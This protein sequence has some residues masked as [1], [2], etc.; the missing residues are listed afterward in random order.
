MQFIA[1][2]LLYSTL[3]IFAF[4]V[5]CL[6][7]FRKTWLL[8][9]LRANVGMLLLFAG[10]GG[11]IGLVLLADME[12]M[13]GEIQYGQ[14][15]VRPFGGGFKL[16]RLN[17]ERIGERDVELTSKDWRL[18]AISIQWTGFLPTFGLTDGVLLYDLQQSNGLGSITSTII[19]HQ[20]VVK[21]WEFGR[22]FLQWL[23]G[24]QFEFLS[25][26]WLSSDLFTLYDLRVTKAGFSVKDL[27]SLPK[28]GTAA[29]LFQDQESKVLDANSAEPVVET[30]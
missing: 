29:A 9:W 1:G 22:L 12:P 18:R 16:I 10:L 8:A 2:L 5:G 21:V 11:G 26:P 17:A 15:E 3:F 23:P 13:A 6:L 24:V 7:L 28:Q 27:K 4:I 20:A 14:A 19:E 25:T 30:P